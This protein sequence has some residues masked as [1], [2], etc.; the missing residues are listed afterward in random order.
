MFRYSYIACLVNRRFYVL[1]RPPLQPILIQE[2]WFC[3]LIRRPTAC[4][5]YLLYD[6]YS[7][8]NRF[9][10][11]WLVTDDGFDDDDDDDYDE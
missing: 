7:D 5:N 8:R 10:K 2:V 6:Q 3:S 11:V 4:L 9:I 1:K